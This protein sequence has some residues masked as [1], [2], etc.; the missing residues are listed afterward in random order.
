MAGTYDRSVTR[1]LVKLAEEIKCVKDFQKAI[2]QFYVD[3]KV[4]WGRMKVITEFTLML[5]D[6]FPENAVDII[7]TF[8]EAHQSVFEESENGDA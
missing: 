2:R 4:N 3:K 5:L 8:C 6:K 1:E 7:S